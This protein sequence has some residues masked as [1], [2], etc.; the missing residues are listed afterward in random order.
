MKSLLLSTAPLK[1]DDIDRMALCC[2]DAVV[3]DTRSHD[4]Y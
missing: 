3:I 2:P 4:L 1:C